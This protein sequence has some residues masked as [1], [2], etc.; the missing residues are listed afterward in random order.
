MESF[1]HVAHIHKGMIQARFFPAYIYKWPIT[2]MGWNSTKWL[3]EK[4]HQIMWKG[5]GK[6]PFFGACSSTVCLSH[7]CITEKVVP[8]GLPPGH[9]H[10]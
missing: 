2:C 1:S 8:A 7:D 9:G 4:L 6:C 10:L 3:I 5:Q